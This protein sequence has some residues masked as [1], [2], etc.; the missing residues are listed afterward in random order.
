M[1]KVKV[2]KG[3]R[4]Y[5]CN[6]RATCDMMQFG[7]EIMSTKLEQTGGTMLEN[8]LVGDSILEDNSAAWRSYNNFDK[9]CNKQCCNPEGGESTCSALSGTTSNF[10]KFTNPTQSQANHMR[11]TTAFF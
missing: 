6:N 2:T 3:D 7:V 4:D 1:G 9:A 10:V 8:D 5:L 11:A